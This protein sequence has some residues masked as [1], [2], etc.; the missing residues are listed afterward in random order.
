MKLLHRSLHLFSL[1]LAGCI[2]LSTSMVSA[3]SVWNQNGDY[4]ANR[5]TSAYRTWQVADPDPNGLNCRMA[6]QYRPAL[7]ESQNM[8]S[9]NI[10]DNRYSIGSWPILVKLPA[11]TRLSAPLVGRGGTSQTIILDADRRPWLALN[12]Y[13]G[14]CLVRANSRYIQPIPASR[15][16]SP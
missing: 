6:F 1:A 9:T 15:V 4:Q 14:A 3:Q 12:T 2:S 16:S 5:E 7:F 11:G 8:N 10:E 13:L